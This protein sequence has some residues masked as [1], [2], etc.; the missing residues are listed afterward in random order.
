MNT[1]V[2]SDLAFLSFTDTVTYLT[3]NHTLDAA[4]RFDEEVERLLGNLRSFKH[5]C[6]PY[7]R[8]PAL[9]K[10]VVNRNTSLIYR[11]DGNTLHL[12]TFFDNRGIHPF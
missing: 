4:V 3:E 1:I 9:R 10:C 6:P 7:E 2:W 5:Y 12:V 8:R 11:V